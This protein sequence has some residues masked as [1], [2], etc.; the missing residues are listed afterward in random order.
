M[1]EAVLALKNICSKNKNIFLYLLKILITTALLF[2]LVRLVDVQNIIYLLGRAETGFI[3]LAFI[4]GLVNIYLQYLKWKLVCRSML[5]V[6]NNKIIL[7]SLFYGFTAGTFTPVRIGEYFGRAA[8]FKE[9]TLPQVA[10]AVLVD[11]LFSFLIVIIIGSSSFLL[12][13]DCSFLQTVIWEIGTLVLIYF[14]F[15]GISIKPASLKYIWIQRLISGLSSI[16]KLNRNHKFR[17]TI[18]SLLFYSCFILQFALLI[19]AFSFHSDFIVFIWT[20][21]LVMFV[22][23]LIPSLFWG[24]LGIREGSTIYFISH[25]GGSVAAGL[26]ASLFLFLINIIFTALLGMIFFLRKK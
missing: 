12:Y 16:K 24:D 14:L 23:T 3:F 21:N 26:N 9:R 18:L 17:L 2:Y 1:A 15:K 22:K 11:K 4:L 5:E 13:L 6:N 20:G 19:S 8:S 10:S 25:F 7:Q